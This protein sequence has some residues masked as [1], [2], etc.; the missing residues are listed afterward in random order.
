MDSPLI[1]IVIVCRNAAA[2]VQHALE[3]VFCQTDRGWELIVIDGSS[4]DGTVQVIKNFTERISVFVSEP[5]SGVY[6]GMNKGIRNARGEWLLFLGADDR[7]SGRDVLAEIRRMLIGA[8]SGI[9]CGEAQYEDGRVWRAPAKPW[10]LYR[11]FMHH[12][13]CFYHCSLF[14]E[15]GYDERYRIQ[16]DYE[17]NLRFW[18]SGVRPRP[19]PILVAVC[20]VGGLSDAGNWINYREEIAI[21]HRY[22]GALRCVVWDLASVLRF[23]RKKIVL[24]WFRK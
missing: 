15:A 23:L 14:R 8:E 19:I 4:N 21:R 24:R 18:R 9:F 11:N 13:G 20:G 22:Y 6:S 16:A 3:S 2:T 5:D 1:S 12:Q 7:L 17:A 10:I